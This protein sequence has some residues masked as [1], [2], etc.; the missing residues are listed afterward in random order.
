MSM[1]EKWLFFPLALSNKRVFT[2]TVPPLLS[3]PTANLYLFAGCV[4]NAPEAKKLPPENPRI[5]TLS[6][7]F[8]ASIPI[9][10]RKSFR[11]F[12]RL[13]LIKSEILMH[14]HINYRSARKITRLLSFGSAVSIKFW[15]MLKGGNISKL[16][17]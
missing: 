6:F 1:A 10:V 17:N 4:S 13:S 12:N 7:H 11:K 8:C 2:Q 15:N 14:K 9:N 3:S 5:L 16:M